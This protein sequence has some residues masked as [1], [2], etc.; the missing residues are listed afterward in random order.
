LPRLD[1]NQPPLA[2]GFILE[3]FRTHRRF[4]NAAENLIWNDSALSESRARF[5]R[6]QT[7]KRATDGKIKRVP[8]FRNFVPKFLSAHCFR[9]VSD[10]L[11]R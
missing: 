10:V 8:R 7:T 11:S 2:S 5:G 1:V 4:S 9:S 6:L 3:M